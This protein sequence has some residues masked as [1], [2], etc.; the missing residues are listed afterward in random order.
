MER[1]A[2]VKA[3][4]QAALDEEP[5]GRAAFVREAC[6]KDE[7]LRGEVESLLAYGGAAEAFLELP[8][9]ELTAR[10]LGSQSK[11]WSGGRSVTTRSNVSSAPAAWARCTWL[12]IRGW[13]G[14]WP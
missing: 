3:V 12:G 11:R 13:T 2:K 14:Q 5:A 4:Y 10:E 6:G 7:G 1:W 8:A 9:M